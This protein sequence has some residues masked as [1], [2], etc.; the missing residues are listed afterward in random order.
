MNL[1]LDKLLL[2]LAKD[3]SH[4][5][6]RRYEHAVRS[7]RCMLGLAAFLANLETDVLRLE[8]ELLGHVASRGVTWR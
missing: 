2:R 3:L 1:D 6:R 8:R 4:L 7:K 5:D